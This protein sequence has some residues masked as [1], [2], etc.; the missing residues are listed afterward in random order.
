MEK[1]GDMIKIRNLK[2]IDRLINQSRKTKKKIL[3]RILKNKQIPKKYIL[4]LK[5]KNSLLKNLKKE[6]SKFTI[7]SKNQKINLNMDYE[8][9]GLKKDLLY[10]EKGENALLKYL[11]SLDKDFSKQKNKIIE[12]LTGKNFDIFITDR[13]GT[14][15]NYSER[16]SSSVQ[17]I[18]NAVFLARFISS[19]TEYSVILTSASLEDFKQVNIFPKWFAKK[20]NLIFSGSKGSEFL[21]KNGRKVRI[22]LDKLERK[23][24]R[25]LERKIKNLLSRKKYKIFS[26]IGS[27]F[28]IKHGQLTIA[29][30]DFV[31]SLD[32]ELSEE[33]SNKINGLVK[34]IDPKSDYFTINDTGT[35]I[36][37][38]LKLKGQKFDKAR[39]I[40]FIL[41][42][43]YLKPRDPLIC[44]DTNSDLIFFDYLNK[45]TKDL[46]AVFVTTDTK[47]KKKAKEIFPETIFVSSPDTLIAA[48]N[49]ISKKQNSKPSKVK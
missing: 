47:I 15:N 12:N 40:R 44:G 26:L 17:S 22:P 34:K 13:D 32:N 35:D 24:L 7:Y 31:G 18:Y 41:R 20:H 6:N 1:S 27:G 48:L 38:T 45:T 49:E 33:F 14:I 46:K 16:Y 30:Q 23:K 9:S 28:Q 42:K 36:E 11:L 2:E 4:R 39:G 43:L 21:L 29:K 10:L 19:K 3:L 25:I 5:K 37:I 8:L